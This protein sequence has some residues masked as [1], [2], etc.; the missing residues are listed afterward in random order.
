MDLTKEQ[1]RDI[2]VVMKEMGF[3][4]KH[5]PASLTLAAPTLTG[6]FQ[7]NANQFGLFADPYARPQRWSTVA[8]PPR[9]IFQLAALRKSEFVKERLDLMSGVTAAAGTNATNWC[10]NPPTVGQGKIAAQD[11]EW[12]EYFIKTNLNALPLLGQVRR[13]EVPAQ[14]LNQPAESR[15][16]LIPSMMYVL[17]N[18]RSQLAYELYLIGVHLERTIDS[19]G[20][21]G[22]HTQASASTEIGWISEFTGLDG[23]IKTGY[24]DARTG[25]AV[26]AAD[27]AVV[28]FNGLISSTN[29]TYG[30]YVQAMSDLIWGLK[31]RAMVYG[32]DEAQFAIVM[33][34]E[35]FRASVENWACNYATYRCQSSNAGQPFVNDV[36]DTNQLR[37]EMMNGQYLLVD[38][39][40]VPVVFSE[41]I[42]RT[43]QGGGLFIDDQYVVPYSWN[44]IP[45][46]SLEY[47]D[48]NNPYLQDYAGFVNPDSHKTMNDGMW[49]VGSRDAGMCEEYLFAS[50]MR[51]ILETPWLAG[52]LD[53][54]GYKFTASIRSAQPGDTFNYADGGR[55][56]IDADTNW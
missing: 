24:T 25:I 52:R 22:D 44:G 54:V 40:P 20:I 47:F 41:G 42:P 17:D 51:L 46:L 9:G 31:Q 34:R 50:R 28:P 23:Q 5:D 18:P 10:G 26:P 7:G 1:I 36:R 21:T 11:Y 4:Q 16:P 19:V 39:Q 56:F 35:A 53:D 8:R 27:S 33:R 14:I 3:T 49:L 30:N 45:L 43:S 15:N 6:P 13:G 12:G 55:T 2:A 29:T 38:G 32:M 37:L 48:L